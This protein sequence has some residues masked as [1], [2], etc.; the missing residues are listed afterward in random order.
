MSDETEFDKALILAGDF[1]NIKLKRKL[2]HPNLPGYFL[3]VDNLAEKNK[4]IFVFEGKQN[5]EYSAASQLQERPKS[6]KLFKSEYVKRTAF[7]DYI[8]IRLFYYS[9]KRKVISEFNSYEF[10]IFTS[11][12]LD[13]N[14]L[15]NIL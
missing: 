10:K 11:Q 9:F 6:L 8:F 14:D 15:A 1:F 4:T 7:S 3:E 12:F 2:F 13:L 5:R